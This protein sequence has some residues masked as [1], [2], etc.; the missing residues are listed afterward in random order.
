MID[1]LHGRTATQSEKFPGTK[2][3][4]DLILDPPTLSAAFPNLF[5]EYIT[6]DGKLRMKLDLAMGIFHQR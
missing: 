3:I 1:S 6:P 4:P 5:E 2:N